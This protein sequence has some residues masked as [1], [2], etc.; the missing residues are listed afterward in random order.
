MGSEA[1]AG[2]L[3][4]LFQIDRL[5]EIDDDGAFFYPGQVILENT[6]GIYDGHGDY[7]HP[8]LF[9]Y[10]KA[11]LM[12]GKEGIVYLVPCTL[13][14]DTEGMPVLYFVYAL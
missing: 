1:L 13:G 5:A 11:A 2:L 7:G 10:F 4:K 6:G 9:R 14:K 3:I 12:E 8:A